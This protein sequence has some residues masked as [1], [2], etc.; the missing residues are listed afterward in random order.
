MN[1]NFGK[2]LD[3]YG[4]SCIWIT[5][6]DEWRGDPDWKHLER[7]AVVGADLYLTLD[8]NREPD[9]WAAVYGHLAEGI[10][11]MLRI[12]PKPAERADIPTLNRYWA[13]AYERIAPWLDDP[14]MKLIQVGMQITASRSEPEGARAYR[15]RDI[16]RMVQQQFGEHGGAL[17]RRGTPQRNVP[18]GRGRPSSGR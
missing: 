8:H 16:A 11:R 4:H 17:V 14:D 6:H 18:R 7:L 2:V 1:P 12:K 9:V 3:A 13:R 15:A 10:G 5:D